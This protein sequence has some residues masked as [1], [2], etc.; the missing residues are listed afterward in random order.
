MNPLDVSSR[1]RYLLDWQLCGRACPSEYR[2]PPS[3]CGEYDRRT[4]QQ[5]KDDKTVKSIS[6]TD[7]SQLIQAGEKVR[8]FLRPGGRQPP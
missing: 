3:Q 5:S 2:P 8:A 6:S 1:I 4:W 7:K